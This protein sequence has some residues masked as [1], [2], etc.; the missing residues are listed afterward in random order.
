MIKALSLLFLVSCLNVWAV[1]YTADANC[2]GA[3][4]FTENT[5]TQVDDSSSNS[6]VGNFASA[7]H[8]AWAA[9][10]GT[11]A[12]AYESYMVDFDGTNDYIDMGNSS[13]LGYTT[14]NFTIVMWI[15]FDAQDCIFL[16]RG[17]Y[18]DKGYYFQLSNFDYKLLFMNMV[19]GGTETATSSVST[20][21]WYHLAF[22]REGTS[23]DKIYINGS[24][25]SYLSQ[26]N[27]A[28]ETSNTY[29]F[30]LGQYDTGSLRLNG[31]MGEIAVFSRA[32]SSTEIN[33]IKTYGLKPAAASGYSGQVI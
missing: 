19:G 12:P 24:E 18:G 32:L 7:G 23:G 13:T 15:Y 17:H 31:K 9:M 8:P 10:T 20:G 4:L 28:N 2:V 25:A 3:W 6:N 27:G 33:N 5:G 22:V 21:Q 1:D 29:N 16:N 30:Q 11:G 14:G 26:A